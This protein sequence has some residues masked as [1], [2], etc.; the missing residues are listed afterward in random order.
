M[1]WTEIIIMLTP[2]MGGLGIVIFKMGR[3]ANRMDF[4]QE[5]ITALAVRL[6]RLEAKMDRFQTRLNKLAIQVA[7]LRIKPR[8]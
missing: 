2:I 3:L 6:D 5:T 8:R 7:K 1:D 4:M